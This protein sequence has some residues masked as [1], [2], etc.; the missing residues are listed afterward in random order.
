MNTSDVMQNRLQSI[1]RSLALSG[2]DSN[3]K[4]RTL[5]A[6]DLGT[7]SVHMV[8]VK[9][10]PDLPAFN[11]IDAEKAT[12][13]LG[14]RCPQTGQLTIEAMGR[15][16]AALRRCQEIA[17]AWKVE[18]TLAVATSAV[19]E[20]PNGKDFLLRIETE[21][22]LKVNL[23]SGQEEARRIYLGVL[24]GIEFDNQ[25]HL[26]IDIGGGSTELIL[27]DEQRPRHLSSTK[28]GAVRLTSEF[29][30]S[31]PISSRDF[32]RLQAYIRG[33]FEWPID[34]LK[35]KIK[36][37]EVVRMVGTSGTIESL[38]R[39]DASEK[40]GNSPVSLH[41]Y[42]LT[43][44]R[45][46][47]IVEKM[48]RLSYAERCKVPGLS[49]KRAE[50]ILAGA[51]ILQEAMAMLGMTELTTCERALREGIVVDWMINHGLIEDRLRYQESIRQRTVLNLAQKYQVDID[52]GQ[53]V[54]K[55]ATH[56]FDQTHGILHHWSKDDRELLWASAILHNCGHY[57]NHSAHHKHSYYLIRNG[58]LLGYT[59]QEIET[60]ANIARYHRKGAPKKKHES[61]Q[62]QGKLQRLMIEQLSAILKV[63]VA[64]DRRRIGAIEVVRCE[65]NRPERELSM[66]LY[67]AKLEDDCQLEQWSLEYKKDCFEAVFNIQVVPKIHQ[68]RPT[69][70]V[71]ELQMS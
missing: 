17:A 38:I 20:A 4:Y 16:I 54:A 51:L 62:S 23:I 15:T 43:R 64:L 19:R 65:F 35:K 57:I 50:I 21:L 22:G 60:I 29:V 32:D 33:M 11:I 59:D 39:I 26:I 25:P 69:A 36:L 49:E 18:Q 46:Q 1:E 31:D 56:I 2:R 30:K 13:R 37:G 7:N 68:E 53:R 40:Q 14:E 70:R 5:A 48:R 58:G 3:P 9:I 6:I 47:A 8:V 52:N 63:A 24:S 55:F 66:H 45:L 12:V 61:Y 28:I 41:G 42:I 10:N 67:P 34:S 71:E 27:A 44:E